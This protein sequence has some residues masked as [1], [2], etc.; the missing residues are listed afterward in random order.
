VLYCYYLLFFV[1]GTLAGVIAL[2]YFVGPIARTLGYAHMFS[3]F[4]ALFPR[5]D[6]SFEVKILKRNV[7]GRTFLKK[8]GILTIDPEKVYIGGGKSRIGIF[9]EGAGTNF[10]PED[11]ALAERT[12]KGEKN[13][14][15]KIKKGDG[16]T[17]N[18][19]FNALI[20]RVR[21]I[22][23]ADALADVVFTAGRAW[24]PVEPE[25][26]KISTIKLVGIGIVILVLF[27]GFYIAKTMG[28]I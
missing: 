20:E 17:V 9:P 1:V 27:I 4:A 16:T 28:Y 19:S 13:P 2:L 7:K 21:S 10:A 23:G 5:I 24:S 14:K 11:A 25:K 15:I 18:V 12:T 26:G 3:K 22:M 8:L 6:R